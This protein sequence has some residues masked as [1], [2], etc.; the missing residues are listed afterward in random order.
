MI[1]DEEEYCPGEGES[2]KA[3]QNAIGGNFFVLSTSRFDHKYK[4]SQVGLK[5]FADFSKRFPKSRLVMVRWGENNDELDDLLCR[6]GLE[7]KV[8]FL[9]LSGKALLRDYLRSAD[10]MLD[11]FVL[12]YFGATGLE[13]MASGLPLVGRIEEDQY[14]AICETGAPPILNASEVEQV[15][16]HLVD[17][18]S[19]ISYRQTISAKVR[20]WFLDNHGS[21]RWAP[22][23]EAVLTATARN[24][25]IDFSKSPLREELSEEEK[26]YHRVGMASAPKSLIY[27]I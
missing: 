16:S 3:W 20:K 23:Y 10:C 21:S 2:R 8:L 11:Q 1:I 7:G 24:V 13:A 22:D 18:Y 26:E 4:G 14:D 25:P 17:L 27:S 19:N 12:G 15:T 6:Y 5:G 9:P